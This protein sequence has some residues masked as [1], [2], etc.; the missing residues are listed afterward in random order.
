MADLYI[1]LDGLARTRDSIDRVERLLREPLDTMASRA[2]AATEIDV[3]RSRLAEF[4]E[5][6]DYGIGRL[7][8]YSEG[9]AEALEQ[10]RRT[11]TE[12]DEKLAATFETEA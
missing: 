2:S 5:E 6:W 11:F 1:D 3:L 10:I 8:K 4:G 12:L 7:A 9:V